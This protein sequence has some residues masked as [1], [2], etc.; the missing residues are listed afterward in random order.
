MHSS[1]ISEKHLTK[2]KGSTIKFVNGYYL[3]NTFYC[4]VDAIEIADLVKRVKRIVEWNNG[5]NHRT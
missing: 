2:G 5:N 3:D 4:A 1:Q